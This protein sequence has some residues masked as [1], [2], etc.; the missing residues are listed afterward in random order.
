[1]IN[2]FGVEKIGEI[3]LNKHSK[4]LLAKITN[5]LTIIVNNCNVN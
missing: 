3:N 1:M 2:P 5:N 4:K